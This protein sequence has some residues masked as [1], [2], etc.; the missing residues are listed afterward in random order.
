[1]AE[2]QKPLEVEGTHDQ[3]QQC[4]LGGFPVQREAWSFP[5]CRVRSWIRLHDSADT[6]VISKVL[7]EKGKEKGE[8]MLGRIEVFYVHVTLNPMR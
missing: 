8:G 2:E 6:T 5:N 7:A 4:R 3:E 1:M